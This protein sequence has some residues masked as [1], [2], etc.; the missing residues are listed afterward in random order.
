MEL[1]LRPPRASAAQLPAAAALSPE[2][3]AAL[4][5]RLARAQRRL[6]RHSL[7]R[8]PTHRIC[9]RRSQ[10]MVIRLA[11]LDLQWSAVKEE[12]DATL[13]WMDRWEQGELQNLAPP[14]KVCVRAR[15]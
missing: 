12:K 6:L 10:Y 2:A 4:A 14:R 8:P 11:A 5:A 1:S 7:W 15:G 3:R 9:L 13:L